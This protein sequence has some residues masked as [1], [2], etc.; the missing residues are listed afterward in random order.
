MLIQSSLPS[1][2]EAALF[3]VSDN[4]K[5]EIPCDWM[6]SAETWQVC[7]KRENYSLDCCR[8]EEAMQEDRRNADDPCSSNYLSSLGRPST[9]STMTENTVPHIV[10]R[11]KRLRNKSTA[12]LL[13]IGPMNGQTS[14]HCP[15]VISSCAHL[16]SAEDQ[17]AGSQVKHEIEMVKDPIVP[18]VICDGATENGMLKNLGID[19]VNDSC[20]SSKSNMEIASDSIETEMDETGECSSSSVAVMDILRE[21]LSAKDFCIKILRSHGLL[22]GD[23][24]ANNVGEAATAGN[25]SYSRSCK[26][27]DHSDGS[28]NM[29]ICDHCEE[30][31]HPSCCIPRLKKFPVDDWFCHSCQKR[32]QKILKEMIIRNSPAIESEMDIFGDASVNG[33]LSPILLMLNDS[34]PNRTGVRVGKG[35]QAEVPDWSGPTRSD[36]DDLAEPLEI[37]PSEFTSLLEGNIRKPTRLSSIG[38]WLQCQE[39]VDRVN[40][41]ICG[42]WRRAP[43]FEVQT[44]DWECFCAIH[45][46]PAHA[47]CAVPQEL[48]TDEVLKQLK[49]IEMLRPRLSARPKKPD[50]TKNDSCASNVDSQYIKFDPSSLHHCLPVWPDHN[51]I[52]RYGKGSSNT[53]SFVLSFPR[54]TNSY[55][56]IG[57]SQDGTM[58]GSSAVAA[59]VAPPTTTNHGS[60][61]QYYLGGTTQNQVLASKG[62]LSL[63][64]DSAFY[65]TSTLFLA[66]QLQ[67]I[68]KEPS[69]HLLFAIGPN[70]FFPSPPNYLLSIHIDRISIKVD[71]ESGEI[72]VISNLELKRSHG[73]LNIVGWSVVMIIGAIIGRYCKQW[74]P[75]WFYLH[76]SIQTLAFLAGIA[77][78]FCGFYLSK[79]LSSNVT[80]HKNIGILIL[81]LGSL[82]VL[83]LVLRPGKESK[84]RK[85]WNYY[86]HNVGRMLIIFAL[87]NTFYGLHLGGEGSKW[88]GGYGIAIGILLILALILEIRMRFMKSKTQK[89]NPTNEVDFTSIM[90]VRSEDDSCASKIDNNEHIPFDTTSL[91]HCVPVWDAYNAILRVMSFPRNISSY[92]AIGFSKDGRMVGS[93]AVV[94]W[95]EPTTNNNKYMQYYLG[96]TKPDQVL[97]L[98]GELPW[99]SQ[100][101]YFTSST[102]FLVFQLQ[103]N[104]PSSFLL[105][106][107]GP[108]GFFPSG[109]DY[110][111]SKHRDKISLIID[112]GTGKV[113]GISE[114]NLKLKRGHGSLNIVGWSVLMI[115]GLIIA[116][117]CK[118]WDP[119]WFYFHI[120]IQTIAFFAGIVGIICGLALSNKLSSNFTHHRNIGI[121]ILVLGFLQV[122]AFVLRPGKESKIRKYWNYYHHNVGRMLIIFALANTFYG[123]HL[124]GEGS[125]WFAG[126][127]ITIA[128]LVIL[129]ILLEIRMRFMNSRT[130]KPNQNDM[131]NFYY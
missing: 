75:I 84:I 32:K 90:V 57:F 34:E 89:P 4:G 121:L 118:Q 74:D 69:S 54:D 35:F 39:V 85:Y 87:A 26:I 12:P 101:A 93:S 102:M 58:V 116:R 11:R 81:V 42:K 61:L 120:S 37:N 22:G 79:N 3:Y 7:L 55:G 112:Y 41:T 67:N 98:K 59:W 56:A 40:G 49:Y 24:H 25:S 99:T 126:Y 14:V 97:F 114:R 113:K 127:G 83:A 129:I 31:F 110:V 96:G 10:Y 105:F 1:S 124:G 95:V 76:A 104:D 78:I 60:Y 27:C 18:V 50:C 53:W 70:G 100:S 28:L 91:Q 72:K 38:N 13:K 19:S 51:F 47:D 17:P 92:G 123:L 62:D 117:Y 119:F 109:P 77:A 33:G 122:M 130:P 6:P 80:L 108:S 131:P 103:T 30:A 86:H 82:Q 71:Y 52:L 107:V 21:D 48:E 125:K 36:D 88:F 44:D 45:W 2:T 8:K 94:G 66:F 15:S 63:A 128:I 20:S 65:S 68:E 43:L 73:W 64:S 9:A 23:S 16:S 115:I 106:A 5:E 29:L 46:D 111:L